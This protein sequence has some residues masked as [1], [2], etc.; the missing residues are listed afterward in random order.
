MT[1]A[2]HRRKPP[3]PG[4]LARELRTLLAAAGLPQSDTDQRDRAHGLVITDKGD[5]AVIEWFVSRSLR[6]A[7]AD[8]QLRGIPM[9]AA[10][11]AHESARR[12]LH[13]AVFA[14]LIDA[15]YRIDSEH[16][17][18][19]GGLLVHAQRNGDPT[20]LAADLRRI[21]AD[22]QPPRTDTSEPITEQ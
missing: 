9:A 6:R 21:I 8:E 18:G 3:A 5:T 1:T 19:T 7:A 10:G 20:T 2:E 14:L 16:V 11:H 22:L 4:P 15:G 13:G 12:H 17:N